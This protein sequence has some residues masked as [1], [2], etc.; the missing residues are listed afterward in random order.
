MTSQD[1]LTRVLIPF[2]L[3]CLGMRTIHI[4]CVPYVHSILDKSLFIPQ[5]N[6]AFTMYISVQFFRHAGVSSTYPG[7]SV[8]KFLKAHAN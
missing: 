5:A 7:E 8:L 1:Y 4:I 2:I 3:A 6:D